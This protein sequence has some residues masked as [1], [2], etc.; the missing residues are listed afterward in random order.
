MWI[1]FGVME[2]Y[3]I[4]QFVNGLIDV[5]GILSAE[6]GEVAISQ[7][8]ALLPG[9]TIMMWIF[10]AITVIFLAAH[11][12]AVGYAVSATCSKGL[13]E[14]EDPSPRT[15]L[16]WC[17]MLT[18]LPLAIIFS[19]APLDTMKTATVV[20]ALPFIIVILIQTFGL[21]KW[22]REDYSTLPSYLIEKGEKNDSLRM[23]QEGQLIK[24]VSEEVVTLVKNVEIRSN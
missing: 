13:R 17:V 8:L 1:F 6:G 19:K 20:T 16:F 18:L 22:L 14:G 21:I 12:D 10:L 7:L 3:S 11:M 23:L 24:E 5:P 4:Y 9:G 15:R 2:N